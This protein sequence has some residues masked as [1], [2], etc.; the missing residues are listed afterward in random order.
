M[1]QTFHKP[2]SYVT[3]WRR[4]LGI[5]F[6]KDSNGL[7]LLVNLCTL[8]YL[9]KVLLVSS[10]SPIPISPSRIKNHKVLKVFTTLRGRK[11]KQTE[12]NWRGKS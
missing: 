5:I 7:W 6:D 11:W 10:R 4:R 1:K 2:Y 9:H 12:R 8:Y 3:S